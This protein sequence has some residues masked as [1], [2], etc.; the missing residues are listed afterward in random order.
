[1][2][3]M[4]IRSVMDK[5]FDPNYLGLLLS[6]IYFFMINDCRY[7]LE[8]TL[9]NELRLWYYRCRKAGYVPFVEPEPTKES[10]IFDV[11]SADIHKE[12]EKR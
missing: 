12:S 6:D 7:Q 3:G 11:Y 4:R 5:K 10:L 2:Y 1:M 8:P 9:R